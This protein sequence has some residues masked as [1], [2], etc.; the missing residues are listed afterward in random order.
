M[1]WLKRIGGGLL[2]LIVITYVGSIGFAY[3]PRAEQPAETLALPGDLFAEVDGHRIRYRS[4]GE[5]PDQPTVM[6]LH[7]FA[8]TLN[9]FSK[10]G[11]ILGEDINVVAVDIMPFGL[12]DKPVDY[13]YTFPNQ[14]RT[15]ARLAEKLG[16]QELVIAGHSYGG[17]VASYMAANEP[18][19]KKLVLIDPGIQATGVP[20]FVKHMVW[21]FR[22]MGARMF[23]G[24]DFRRKFV[25]K[26]FEEPSLIDDAF[27]DE[28]VLG[29]KMDG[30]MDGTT[31]FFSQYMDVEVQWLFDNVKVPTLL[32]WGKQ[33]KNNPPRFGEEMDAALADSRL[34]VIDQSGHYPHMEQP[35]QLSAHVKQFVHKPAP[36]PVA[37][38]ADEPTTGEAPL[39]IPQPSEIKLVREPA[40]APEPKN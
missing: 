15:L 8:G 4:W 30:Y 39:P 20:P 28:L 13:D 34:V 32:I 17:T 6:F 7:G 16:I 33:D 9:A 25:V 5:H 29:T 2:A 22:R 21:P 35:E 36:A 19:V 3:W 14:A 18:I 1:A 40:D 37:E 10:V 27:V 26:S 23:T 38:P 12:S 24:W 31:S 11:P